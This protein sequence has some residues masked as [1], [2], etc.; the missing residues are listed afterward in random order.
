VDV[1]WLVSLQ[2]LASAGVLMGIHYVPSLIIFVE[3]SLITFCSYVLQMMC[4]YILEGKELEFYMKKIQ[5]K[6][7][8]GAA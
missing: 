1:C 5:K 3:T 7:G 8:K 4:R 2:G 6:K